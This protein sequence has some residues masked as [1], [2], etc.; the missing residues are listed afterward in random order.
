L[1]GFG[2]DL[3]S[4]AYV[5]SQWTGIPC[6][7]ACIPSAPGT[8]IQAGIVGAASRVAR[9]ARFARDYNTKIRFFFMNTSPAEKSPWVRRSTTVRFIRWLFSRKTV[10]RLLFAI[11][12]LA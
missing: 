4:A 10:G 3:D 7:G 6:G 9:L 12:T 2:R 5:Q 11:L 1:P 8:G